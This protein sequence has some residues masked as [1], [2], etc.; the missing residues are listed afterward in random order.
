MKLLLVTAYLSLADGLEW[1]RQPS[2]VLATASRSSLTRSALAFRG[3]RSSPEPRSAGGFW[4]SVRDLRCSLSAGL[5]FGSG[6]LLAQTAPAQDNAAIK[7]FTDTYCFECHN[8]LDTG[9]NLNLERDFALPADAEIWEKVVQKLDMR[10]MP[11]LGSEKPSEQEYASTATLLA[12]QLDAAAVRQPRAGQPLLHRLN[13]T[14]YATVIHDLLGL[15]IRADELLPPDD[16]AFGFDNNANVL[17]LSPVLLE[18]YLSAADLISSLALGDLAAQPLATTYRVKLDLSQDQHIEGLPLGTVGGLKV[19]HFFPLDGEYEFS[20]NLLRTNLEYMRGIELPHQLEMSVDGQRIFLGTVGGPDDLALMSNPTNGSDAIDNR[21]RVRVPVTAG[22]HEVVVTF[23][24]KRA[25]S[26]GRLQGF[27]RSSVDTFEAV[28]RPHLEMMT[29]KGPFNATGAGDTNSRST[30]LTCQ[31]AANSS[32]A[33][34]LACARVILSTLATRAYRRPLTEEDIAPL[35]DFFAQGRAKGSFDAGIQMGLRRILASPAFI[36]RP[37]NSPANIAP[38]SLYRLPDL[39]LASQLSFFLWSSIPDDTLL[40]LAVANQLHEPGVLRAQ[41]QRMLADPKASRFVE[42]FAGQWLQL[43]NLN[44]A[45]PNSADYPNFDDNLRTGF[46][47]ETELLFASVLQEQRSVLDLLRADYTFV[48]ER[49]AKH[50]GI[51]NVYGSQFRRVPVTD[52]A[53]LGIL[54]HGSVLTVTS[55]ADR[56]SPVVRGKWVLENL[57]AAPPP[58]PPPD[59]PA[60]QANEENVLP[61]SLRAR[62][63]QHRENPVCASCHAVMDPIGFSLENFDA[64]GEWRTQEAGQPIDAHGVLADGSE[65]NGVVSL[66]SALL[67]RPELFVSAVTQKLMIYALGRG[68]E[69]GDMPSVRKVV[70]DSAQQNYTLASLIVGIVESAPFQMRSAPVEKQ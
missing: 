36:F 27:V 40:K 6:L 19:E 56:T 58:P 66:R 18:R 39:E 52:E 25:V 63:E 64:V 24:Q 57:L 30:V 26:T 44:N 38:G 68:I 13:R 31:P 29:V 42:N 23:I 1:S 50:Y 5:F 65:V 32:K 35:L 46:R 51:P 4:T 59:V 22:A 70:L 12:T 60:L 49:L 2:E 69:A 17:G 37:E 15:N 67:S 43:R 53:R 8:L 45:R 16:S 34:E 61:K 54:G 11:P 9:A 21:M 10:T 20:A 47:K 3:Q 14:E 41:T 7:A 48:N 33:D 28:G 62:L 55:H